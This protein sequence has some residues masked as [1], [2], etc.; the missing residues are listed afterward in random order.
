MTDSA[1]LIR[2]RKTVANAAAIGT[3]AFGA[4]GGVWGAP[5]GGAPPP[6]RCLPIRPHL[7]IPRRRHRPGQRFPWWGN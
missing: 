7:P 6:I 5:P 1:R 3:L 4:A 2:V